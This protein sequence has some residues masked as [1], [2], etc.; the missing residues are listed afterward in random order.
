MCF[1]LSFPLFIHI[2][3]WLNTSLSIRK[4]YEYINLYLSVKTVVH[5][6]VVGKLW[7]DQH[8]EMEVINHFTGD[9]CH[10]KFEPY[11]YFSGVAKKVIGTI[12][13]KS[14]KVEWVLNGTWDAKLEGSKVIGE[15]KT[16]GKSNLEIENSR[17]LWSAHP[18]YPGSEKF[19]NFSKFTCELNEEE[20]GVAPT[21][22][23]LRPDQR[24]ME[25][26]R[27]DE[28][29]TEKV[30]LEEK[31][32]AVRRTRELEAEKA[33]QEGMPYEGHKPIWFAKVKDDQNGEKLI[34]TYLG[35]YWE[36]KEKQNWDMC[37]DIF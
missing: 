17:V 19:Y 10:M 3:F 9:K 29:N 1:H 24:L 13:N 30:R 11:S 37:P 7:I 21:D 31:Q 16:K 8:G 26:G 32:R 33:A 22:C 25:E 2:K 34:H 36:A 18:P 35:G 12:T 28:A 4:H 6:I 14:G 23:R 20:E 15:S 5:N 27:W